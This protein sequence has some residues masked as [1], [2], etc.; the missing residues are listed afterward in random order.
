MAD[1]Y[2]DYIKTGQMDA[3]TATKMTVGRST[4]RVGMSRMLANPNLPADAMAFGALDTIAVKLV[5]WYGAAD[6]A[7]VLR[8]YAD[9]CERQNA[10]AEA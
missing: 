10:K 7:K 1:S 5:E 3:L 9:V 8:H 2:S 4:S 6:A